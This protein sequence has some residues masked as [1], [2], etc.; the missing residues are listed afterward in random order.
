MSYRSAS[1]SILASLVLLGAACEEPA[2]LDAHGGYECVEEVTV[3]AGVEVVSELGFSAADVLASAAGSRTASMT[4]SKG[5]DDG[6]ITIELGPEQGEAQL[7]VDIAHAGGEVRY[8]KSTLDGDGADFSNGQCNDRL[9]IDVVVDVNSSGGG[10]AESFTAPLRATTRGIATLR[11]A[12]DLADLAGTFA[13]TKVEPA[14]TEIGALLFDLGVS[15]S[16]LFGGASAT[17][18]LEEGGAALAT[19][20]QVARWGAGG[21]ACEEGFG[22][23][24]VG[25]D[26]QI[27]GFSA[28]DALALVAGAGDLSLTWKGAAPTAMSLELTHDGEAVCARYEGDAVGTLRFAASA[29]VTTAD[30]RWT[31]EFPVEVLAQPAADGALEAVRIQI[32]A[33][34]ASTV[35][36]ADFAATFGIADIDFSGYDA[37]GLDFTGEYRPEGEGTFVGG[38]VTVLGVKLPMCSNQPDEGCEGNDY[39]ELAN[40]S[41]SQP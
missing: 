33:P 3:L 1:A 28:A 12:I 29:A 5:I 30:G 35:P 10:F 34:Y 39:T 24:P 17:V 15:P 32:P 8:I 21:G 38:Q 22:E 23:A 4:W 25:L 18:V 2:N 36:T 31:G 16:G 6:P 26:D 37:A 7:V 11:H 27:A 19:D 41:W 9:E 40:A 20:M 14:H 13:P